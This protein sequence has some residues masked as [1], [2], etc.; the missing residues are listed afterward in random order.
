MVENNVLA[1]L[2]YLDFCTSDQKWTANYSLRMDSFV[3][4]EFCAAVS[5]IL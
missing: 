5:I 1:I 2:L 3:F 4:G